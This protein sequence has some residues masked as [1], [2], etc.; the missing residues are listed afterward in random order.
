MLEE[1]IWIRD[2]R[3]RGARYAMKGQRILGFCGTIWVQNRLP[4]PLLEIWKILLLFANYAGIGV[5]T[6]LGMGAVESGT[7]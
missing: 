5:K 6:S 2:Y 1:Q 7:G 4:V 3:L